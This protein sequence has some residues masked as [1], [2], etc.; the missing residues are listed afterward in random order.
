VDVLV[1]N[2]TIN[3][4]LLA[5]DPRLDRRVHLTVTGLPAA[6]YHPT[7][8]RVDEQHSNVAAHC[9]ADVDW[10]DDALWARLHAADHLHEERLPDVSGDAASFDFPLPMPGIARIRLAAGH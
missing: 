5:G 10:P 8:A 1:W 6:T 2:G 7:L 9:P 4:A 3:A